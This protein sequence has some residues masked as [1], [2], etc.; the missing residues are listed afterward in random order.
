MPKHNRGKALLHLPSRG[1]GTCP[2]C[3]ATRIKVLYERTAPDGATVKV[4]KR[5]RRKPF[6]ASA[7]VDARAMLKDL[8]LVKA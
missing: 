1:R 8:E 3:H 5:C 6:P 2:I 4:C 7:P